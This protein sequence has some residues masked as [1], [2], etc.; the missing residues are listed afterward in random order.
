MQNVFHPYFCTSF[1]IKMRRLPMKIGSN[2]RKVRK[3]L[4]LS[5]EAVI[6]NCKI[7]LSQA[8]LSKIEND[9]VEIDAESERFLDIAGALGMAPEQIIQFEQHNIT[10]TE[11]SLGENS[12]SGSVQT[13]TEQLL[14]IQNR[15][16]QLFELAYEILTNQKII[17]NK[18]FVHER[19]Y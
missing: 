4:E 10:Q 7:K 13:L 11:P 17:A 9:L 18:L 5:Q 6:R 15:Q 3:L 16:Q 8:T 19:Q 2:I 12:V 14:D 1:H